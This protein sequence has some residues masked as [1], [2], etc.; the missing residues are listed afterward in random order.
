[1]RLHQI[2]FAMRQQM[3][4]GQAVGAESLAGLA[5]F[6]PP[7]LHSLG[8]RLGSAMSRRLFNVVITNVPGPQ[9]TLYA[10]DARML[11]TYPVM[12]LAKGQALAIGLTSYDGGVYYGLNADRDS[13]PDLDVLGQCIVDSLGRAARQPPSQ[14]AMTARPPTRAS[15]GPARGLVLGGGASSAPPG[16]SARSGARG[17]AGRRPARRSTSSSAPRPVRSSPACS[18]RASRC[19]T[20]SSTSSRRAL[21]VGP[22]GRLLLGLRE[23]HRRRPAGVRPGRLW[24]AGAAACATPVTFAPCR[25]PP[26]C[27]R[28]CP[29]GAAA[30]K[31]SARWCA[32]SS[33]RAGSDRSG[34]T[35]VAL[36]Y[37]TGRARAV[38]RRRDR[39]RRT[40]PTAVMASCAIPGWYQPVRIGEHRY[41]DGGAWSSTNLDLMAGL[42]LDEVYV[43]APQV[44]FGCRRAR[45]S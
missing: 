13:M 25:R 19:R 27:R 38:R 8:A 10:G 22:A 42:E 4:G 11:S 34:V 14:G 44:S 6:A 1:M 20:C 23:G 33:R 32:T 2:A 15:R 21:D 35:V 28:S 3:E 18:A 17:R 39:R 16:W 40:S 43:L 30:S 37:D 24:L 45:A 41:I 5:G 9:H 29:R 31:R 36:D 26:C 12:P 7:T